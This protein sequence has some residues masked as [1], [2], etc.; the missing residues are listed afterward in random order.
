MYVMEIATK[1]EDYPH[2][3]QFAY[4]NGYQASSK[5]SPFEIVYGRKCNTPVSWDIPMDCLMVGPKM[6]QDME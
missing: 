2:M 1:W 3:T 4:N 5:M 6:L